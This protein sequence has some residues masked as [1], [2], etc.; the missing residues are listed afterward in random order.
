MNIAYITSMSGIGGGET[1]LVN[2]MQ[3][4]LRLG[5]QP[6]LICPPGA[7]ARLA[8]G[9]NGPEP[10]SVLD[11]GHRAGR[12]IHFPCLMPS[13]HLRYGFLPQTVPVP[14]LKDGLRTGFFQIVRRVM[15]AIRFLKA[16]IVHAESLLGM[17][18]G[19]IAARL[20][21]VPC[22]AS[23][24]GYWPLGTKLRTALNILCQKVF[25]IAQ[26]VADELTS[27]VGLSP[28]RLAVIP[29]ELNPVFFHPL[30]P[31]KAV[32]HCL[33]LPLDAKIVMQVARFQTVKGQ[34]TLLKAF[35]LLLARYP[36]AM[37]R[38]LLLIFVGGT[39]SA[40][41]DEVQYEARIRACV[42]SAE[43]SERVL[44]LGHRNDVPLLL[45]AADV[46]V[47]PSVAET[48]GMS[49]FE[50]AAVGTPVI[51]TNVGG[52][53]TLLRHYENALLVPPESPQDLADAIHKL[54]TDTTL[55]QRIADSGRIL[56][57]TNYAPGT[58]ARR[59]VAEY[60]QLLTDSGRRNQV[61]N[62]NLPSSG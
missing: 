36:E 31:K 46:A 2:T 8:S 59:L 23:Y 43:L 14:Y 1:G 34:L 45:R 57:R 17:I 16:D 26:C 20:A 7:L 9:L 15:N 53:A 24:Y 48:F 18:Y 60:Q 55:A 21:G 22:V 28:E 33:G 10:S 39:M 19:G 32:R 51:A 58:K 13:V 47:N 29:N 50:A 4:I 35:R 61:K 3:S 30:P 25:P 52:P 6:I 54:L 44:F 12:L 37:R 40:Y 56:A 62:H 41:R 42:Q 11:G 27:S 5:H 38:E 49:V